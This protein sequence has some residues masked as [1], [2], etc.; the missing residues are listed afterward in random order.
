MSWSQKQKEKQEKMKNKVLLI[1]SILF[2]FTNNVFSQCAMCK[3]VV[4]TNL[5][6]GGTIGAG[7]NNGILYLMAMPYLSVLIIGLLWY[8]LNKKEKVNS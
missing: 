4:E 1:I 5:E 2:I 8:R 3:S 7:L 6:S